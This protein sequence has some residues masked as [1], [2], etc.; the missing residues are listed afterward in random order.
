MGGARP[1]G[2]PCEP[3]HKGCLSL[4]TGRERDSASGLVFVRGVLAA[5]VG[6]A[7]Q[8]LY[9]LGVCLRRA[10]GARCRSCSRVLPAPPPLPSLFVPVP[11]SATCMYCLPPSEVSYAM[12]PFCPR[13]KPYPAG[14]CTDCRPP[15]VVLQRQ[16]YRCG[17]LLGLV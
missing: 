6:C 7:L 5:C 14:L 9:M 12:K 15:N 8:V 1:C 3:V 4:T 10:W 17:G 11:S 2:V 16:K 13:H